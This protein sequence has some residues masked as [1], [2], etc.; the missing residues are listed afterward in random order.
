[1][2]SCVSLK[3]AAAT[4][5]KV[6]HMDGTMEEYAGAVKA[7]HVAARSPGCYVCS[8]EATTIGEEA[9]RVPEAEELKPGELCY[10]KLVSK[11]SCPLLLPDVCQQALPSAV[12]R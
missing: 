6:I 2:G 10:L 1:M 11:S 7:G 3:E 12:D 8:S 4:T 5:A 9:P